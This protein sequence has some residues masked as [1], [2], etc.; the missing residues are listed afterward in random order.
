MVMSYGDATKVQNLVWGS[1]KSVVPAGVASALESATNY[2][3]S[4]LNIATELTG[5]DKPVR[6][7]AIANELAAGILLEQKEPTEESQATIRGNKMLE[8]Y[9]DETSRKSRGESYHLRF[10]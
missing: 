6:L 9:K 10:A 2:I 7:D 8:S 1:A 5:D 3:N 4:E